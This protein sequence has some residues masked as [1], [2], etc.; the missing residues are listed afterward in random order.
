MQARAEQDNTNH[1][2]YDTWTADFILRINESRAF[3]GKY[4][5][6]LRIPWRHN[7]RDMMAI[8]GIIPVAKW[9]AKIKQ[10]SDAGCRLCK[11]AREQRGAS[12]E[13]LPEETYGH[14]NIAFCDGMVT[15]V[16]AARHFI[17][18][19]LYDS[20]QATQTPASKLRFVAPDKG[21]SV[22]TLWQV[23]EFEQLC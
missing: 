17:W 22:N 20:M 16:T 19:H 14:I 10:R 9:L 18:R 15:I 7:R 6:N 2:A 11:R 8:A 12:T 13:K 21:N 4:L 23:E 3:L 1:P 5:N